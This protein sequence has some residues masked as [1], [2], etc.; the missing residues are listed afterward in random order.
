MRISDWSSDVC[1][2][3]LLGGDLGTAHDGGQRTLRLL[4]RRAEMLQLRLHEPPGG[5]RQQTR[6]A[7]GRGM[8]AVRRREGIV[9]VDIAERRKLLGDR[10]STRLN[11][12]P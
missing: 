1:S 11:S 6:D 12:R 7:F 5:R 10:K 2:S 8:R 4:Q 9:H 3:D